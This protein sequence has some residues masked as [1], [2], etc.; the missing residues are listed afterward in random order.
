MAF[1]FNVVAVVTATVIGVAASVAAF[2]VGSA[3]RVMVVATSSP[4][5]LPSRETGGDS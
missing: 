2:I 4:M 5:L 3:V 1:L